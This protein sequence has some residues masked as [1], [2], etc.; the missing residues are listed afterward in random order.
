MKYN[1]PIIV[2]YHGEWEKMLKLEVFI[3]QSLI[4]YDVPKVGSDFLE[5]SLG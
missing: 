1:Q 2:F 3:H 4:K 5:E